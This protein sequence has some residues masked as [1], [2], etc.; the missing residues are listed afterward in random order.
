MALFVLQAAWEEAVVGEA[1]AVVVHRE[2]V[3]LVEGVVM[4]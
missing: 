4:I 2:A 3:H 1:M